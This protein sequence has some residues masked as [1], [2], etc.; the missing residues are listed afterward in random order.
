MMPKLQGN[1]VCVAEALISMHLV[2]RSRG[3]SGSQSCDHAEML[4]LLPG[5]QLKEPDGMC[6][7]LISRCFKK[8]DGLQKRLMGWTERR[9]L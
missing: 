2:L 4:R 3:E 8:F 5:Q 9:G 1:H 6:D 7:P